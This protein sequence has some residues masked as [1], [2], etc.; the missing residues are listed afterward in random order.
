MTTPLE[1]DLGSVQAPTRVPE[2]SVTWNVSALHGHAQGRVGSFRD[3]RDAGARPPLSE[4]RPRRGGA[5][6][7]RIPGVS[8]HRI[9]GVWSW[10][11]SS[12]GSGISD[13]FLQLRALYQSSIP[14]DD[15]NNHRSGA[16]TLVDARGGTGEISLAG[17][18]V[19]PFFGITNL[20]DREYVTSVETF[21]SNLCVE[22]LPSRSPLPYA[23]ARQGCWGRW[24]G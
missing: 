4:V 24:P 15:A 14:A 19:A 12:P 16:Y 5:T 17:M 9:E 10:E 7:N 22:T 20:L 6:G 23:P 11:G 2:P 18:E 3:F 21:A 1:G 8:P 13:P